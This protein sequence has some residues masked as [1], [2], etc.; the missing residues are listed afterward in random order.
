VTDQE[1]VTAVGAR[2]LVEARQ[3]ALMRLARCTDPEDPTEH[4][5]MA[6]GY[7]N[8]KLSPTEI[9]DRWADLVRAVHLHEMLCAGVIDWTSVDPELVGPGRFD[10]AQRIAVDQMYEAA[11]LLV[12]ARFDRGDVV[13]VVACGTNSGYVTHR[14]RGE[15]ACDPCKAAHTAYQRGRYVPRP[16][17]QLAPCGTVAAYH[18]HLARG[19]TTCQACRV[20]WA[21]YRRDRYLRVA[22]VTR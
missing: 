10:A 5:P 17:R 2:R 21:A 7:A 15:Q 12:G 18:R 20:A 13:S 9:G 8:P 3:E 22:A 19:E 4:L 11:D 6:S 1:A 14:R 16:P